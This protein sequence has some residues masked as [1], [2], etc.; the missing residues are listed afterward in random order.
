[1]RIETSVARGTHRCR[2]LVAHAGRQ[3]ARA[4]QARGGRG[5]AAP[6]VRRGRAAG[7]ARGG[8]AAGR[9]RGAQRLRA[10][11]RVG[12]RARGGGRATSG[13]AACRPAAG[14]SS[15][16]PGSKPLL[17]ALLQALPGDVVLPVPCWVSYAAHA[18]IAG[19][20]VIGVP[21]GEE[22]GGVPDPP[23]LRAALAEAEG[24]GARPGILVLTL[25]DNPTGT[26]ASEALVREVCEVAEAAGLLIVCDEIY[27]DLATSRSASSARP[28]CC[29]S[30]RSSPPA[31]ACSTAPTTSSA[32]GA[33][34]RRPGGAAVD[35]RRARAH[36]RRVAPRAPSSPRRR[37]RRGRGP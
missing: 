22:A 6:G 34:Q 14:R 5:H 16:A 23:H 28:S 12:G 21:I 15:F 29:P 31:R 24:V 8:G 19:K 27:R 26:V 33:A 25:P 9:G 36:A 13:A 30:A 3:R 37:S 32:R 20:R 10:G 7:A 2:A 11:R 18:A 4:R 35:R 1:M 17:Y